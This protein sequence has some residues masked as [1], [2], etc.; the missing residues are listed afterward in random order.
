MVRFSNAIQLAFLRVLFFQN[1]PKLEKYISLYPPELR[2]RDDDSTAVHSGASSGV[3]DEKREKLREWV[4]GMMRAGEMSSEPETLEH[5][6]P[7]QKGMAQQ[8]EG[9][10]DRNETGIEGEEDLNMRQNMD[11]PD[12]FFEDGSGNE[13]S[14]AEE[15][16]NTRS[17]ESPAKRRP[18]KAEHHPDKRS[19]RAEKDPKKAMHKKHRKSLSPATI[20]DTF[21][22]DESE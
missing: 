8:W 17:S 2:S 19:K 20:Q 11:V 18:D 5:R 12:D 13:D 15:P 9:I 14:E 6:Q 21:F 16:V 10:I 4:R 7:V 1:Y 3:S 22:G